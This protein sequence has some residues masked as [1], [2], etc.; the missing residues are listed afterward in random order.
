[1]RVLG[2]ILNRLYTKMDLTGYFS[3]RL[4]ISYYLQMLID[5]MAK[6]YSGTDCRSS[7][8]LIRLRPG[9]LVSFFVQFAFLVDFIIYFLFGKGLNS[10]YLC[11][12][13]QEMAEL[14]CVNCRTLQNLYSAL[15]NRVTYADIKIIS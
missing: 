6:Q 13:N 8:G 12:M 1:M 2:R 15:F 9:A 3:N 11:I 4:A 10:Y 7:F 5:S 14:C